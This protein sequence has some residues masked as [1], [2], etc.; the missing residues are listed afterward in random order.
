MKST[1]SFPVASCIHHVY[2]IMFYSE[3]R[4][5]ISTAIMGQ[6]MGVKNILTE[7]IFT[8]TARIRGVLTSKREIAS[9]DALREHHRARSV[10]RQYFTN[11][12]E[13]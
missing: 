1:T 5:F 13:A 4:I 2:I 3:G 10:Q 9:A 7:S 11:I 12:E 8:W 6:S